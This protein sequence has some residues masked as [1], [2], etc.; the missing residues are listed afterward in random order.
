[1]GGKCCCNVEPNDGQITLT[2]NKKN[3]KVQRKKHETAKGKD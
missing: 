3:D 2:R 1:M